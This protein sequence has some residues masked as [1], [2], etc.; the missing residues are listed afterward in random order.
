MELLVIEKS[1][2]LSSENMVEALLIW[3]IYSG[4]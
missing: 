4:I 3:L 1:H 2:T